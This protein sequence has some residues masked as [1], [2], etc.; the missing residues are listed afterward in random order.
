MRA[1]V[2]GGG[3]YGAAIAVYLKQ[4][5]GFEHV[6]LVEQGE[7]LLARA[8]FANQ[9]RVH[10]GYHYPRSFRTGFRS[11]VNLPRFVEE[12]GDA[13]RKD[14]LAVYAIAAGSLVTAGQFEGFCDSI[15]A[16]LAPAEEAVTNQFDAKRITKVFRVEEFAFSSASL[17]EILAGQLES[18]G[19]EV[20]LETRVRRISQEAS[21]VR[22][23]CENNGTIGSIISDYVFNCSYSGLN[24]I[25]R[26]DSGMP[27]GLKHEIAEMPLVTLPDCLKNV[28]VTVMD[29]PYFSIMPFPDRSSH[30]LS[31]V[32]Y[33]PHRSWV[34]VVGL[35]PYQA[36]RVHSKQ[37][38]FEWM[39]RDAARYLPA[40]AES[41]Q[42]DS[43]F[44][45]KTVLVR[46]EGDDG[47]PILVE[48]Y[49]QMPGLYCILGGKVDNIYDVLERLDVEPLN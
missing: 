21:K 41:E 45:V 31:H 26:S 15:G 42:I 30:T 25:R 11:R 40:I 8:S 36:L 46:S 48:R 32:R 16:K 27:T 43:L 19:V 7:S 1:T 37:S 10:N 28:A 13:V 17:R 14:F 9:A 49:S 12:W 39:R 18:C 3:F 23:E 34:D 33:T 38:R 35:D 20:R 2:V 44:E 24:Q 5:R 6:T 29:G 47:R 4:R 22:T